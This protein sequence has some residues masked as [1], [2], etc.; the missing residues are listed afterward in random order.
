M[1]DIKPQIQKSQFFLNTI[2]KKKSTTRHIILKLYGRKEIN[3]K[4]KSWGGDAEN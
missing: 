3:L 2:N 1:K 4:V